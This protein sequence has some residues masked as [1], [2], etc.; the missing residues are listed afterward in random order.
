MLLSVSM[1]DLCK[2][3]CWLIIEAFVRN[4]RCN[5]KA[6]NNKVY[7]GNCFRM[8]FTMLTVSY[9]SGTSTASVVS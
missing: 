2:C 6:Y 1:W 5:N 4:A 9:C 7:T 3:N 8:S